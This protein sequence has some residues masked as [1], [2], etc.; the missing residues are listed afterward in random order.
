M[1]VFALTTESFAA[2]TYVH[3]YIHWCRSFVCHPYVINVSL[4]HSPSNY[5]LTAPMTCFITDT[6]T[7]TLN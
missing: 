6:H 5:W 2:V 7:H 4:A 1:L 3:A